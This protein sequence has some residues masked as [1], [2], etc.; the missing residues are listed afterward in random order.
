MDNWSEVDFS[1]Y[2]ETMQRL[3]KYIG[4]LGVRLLV[5]EFRGQRLYIPKHPTEDHFLVEIIG[6][7]ALEKL[8][9]AMGGLY[10]SIP[11]CKRISNQSRNN[12]IKKHRQEGWSFPALISHY[13]LSASSLKLILS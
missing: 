4:E 8:S 6:F 5:H 12:R 11:L 9:F 1:L 10:I 13:N 2:P 3:A 7:E